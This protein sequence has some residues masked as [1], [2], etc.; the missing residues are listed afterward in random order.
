MPPATA[1]AMPAMT[2]ERRE[3]AAL[4]QRCALADGRDRG[5]RVARM[6][7]TT[8]AIS[9]TTVPTTSETTIVRV[10]KT[11]PPW[12]MSSPAAR[13]N[14]VSPFASTTPRPRPTT[15]A[16]KPMTPASAMTERSTWRREAPRVRSVAS[17]RERWATVMDSVLKMTNAPT[18]SAMPPNASSRARMKVIAWEIRS[19]SFAACW[20]PVVT[21][22]VAGSSG[23]ISRARAAWG[24][25]GR[26]ATWIA[27]KP[28]LSSSTCAR[29]DVEDGDGGAAQRAR[30]CRRSR[31]R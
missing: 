12:G 8:P 1:T 23:A 25:P 29:R 30:R 16:A 15:E 22:V 31:G 6:A 11:V 9:V 3:L 14:A 28:V 26:A 17:S 5:T 13:K 2:R 21:W 4:G 27:S 20:S 7:G 18:K 10:A 19:L 24:T